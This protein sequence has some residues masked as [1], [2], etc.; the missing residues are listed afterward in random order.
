MPSCIRTPAAA[1][2]RRDAATEC[3]GVGAYAREEMARPSIVGI[4]E[5]RGGEERGR[6]PHSIEL[7]R[8]RKL[9]DQARAR[10]TSGAL[11]PSSS[12]GAMRSSRVL[13]L[14][15]VAVDALRVPQ[16]A[17]RAVPTRLTQDQG[18]ALAAV[19]DQFEQIMAGLP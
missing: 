7:Q 10:E 8:E 1:K 5:A 18:G 2:Q 19:G 12:S 11:Q 16:F 6:L 17:R 3:S 9:V 4:A 14:L 15:L 13:A